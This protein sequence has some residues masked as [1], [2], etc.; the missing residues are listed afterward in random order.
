MHGAWGNTIFH[1][2]ISLTTVTSFRTKTSYLQVIAYHH[3]IFQWTV[4]FDGPFIFGR[5]LLSGI[6][7]KVRK[8]TILAGRCYLRKLWYH[9]SENPAFW[10]S[11]PTLSNWPSTNSRLDI[12]RCIMCWPCH[13]WLINRSVAIGRTVSRSVF[14]SVDRPIDWLPPHLIWGTLTETYDVLPAM[15]KVT[16]SSNR[17]SMPMSGMDSKN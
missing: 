13:F 7:R 3:S 5:T 10:D 6:T 12:D 14:Q 2:I 16:K 15:K 17:S 1:S 8:L 4:T 9:K 11:Q